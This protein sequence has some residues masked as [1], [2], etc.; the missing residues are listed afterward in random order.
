[1]EVERRVW[2]SPALFY[3]LFG[4]ASSACGELLWWC[5]TTSF[6]HGSSGSEYGEEVT[7]MQR[8]LSFDLRPLTR[9]IGQM[10]PLVHDRN[11]ANCFLGSIGYSASFGYVEREP[12]GGMTPVMVMRVSS[13]SSEALS[14]INLASKQMR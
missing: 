10:Q 9:T 4:C 8:L 13:K 14:K 2:K 1:M 11:V 5:L 12:R 7:A 6:G 3:G